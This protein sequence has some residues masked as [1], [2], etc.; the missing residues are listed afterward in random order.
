MSRRSAT[1]VPQDLNLNLPGLFHKFDKILGEENV[2]LFLVP[3]LPG[4]LTSHQSAG[5]FPMVLA[6]SQAN[7]VT[8]S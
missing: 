7:S 8:F 3:Q 1:S 5:I 2:T 6:G 4:V